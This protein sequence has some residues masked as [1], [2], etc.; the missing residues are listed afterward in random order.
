LTNHDDQHVQ[1]FPPQLTTLQQQLLRL[2]G[3]PANAY[4][5]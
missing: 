1:T 4:T 5:A 2:L 3:V